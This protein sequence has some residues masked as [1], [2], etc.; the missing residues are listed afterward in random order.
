MQKNYWF[1]LNWLI[2]PWS[3]FSDLSF[4]ISTNDCLN[5]CNGTL[6]NPFQNIIDASTY[7]FNNINSSSELNVSLLFLN[8]TNEIIDQDLI[9]S[10]FSKTNGVLSIFETFS[11]LNISIQPD[12]NL[13]SADLIIKTNSVLFAI[14]K[15]I[16]LK[17][18]NIILDD[19][20]SSLTQHSLFAFLSDNSIIKIENSEISSISSLFLSVIGNSIL[21]SNLIKNG[22]VLIVNS[23]FINISI[24]IINLNS[25]YFSIEFNNNKIFDSKINISFLQNYLIYF[26]GIFNNILIVSLEIHNISKFL[27]MNENNDLHIANMTISTNNDRLLYF[28]KNN[29]VLIDNL[30]ISDSFNDNNSLIFFDD[31]NTALFSNFISKN[32]GQIF[33]LNK[34]NNLIIVYS[35]FFDILGSFLICQFKNYVNLTQNHINN[36]TTNN[37][38][39]IVYI[40]DV[41][42]TLYF[43]ENIFSDIFAN[44][45]GGIISTFFQAEI[46]LTN[47]LFY[48]LTAGI[49]G[50]FIHCVNCQLKIGNSYFN[51]LTAGLGAFLY[52]NNSNISIYNTTIITISSFYRN[53]QSY[54]YSGG[55]IYCYSL[56]A[57]DFS[58]SIIMNSQNALKGG[59][60]HFEKK[61]H[62]Q[63]ESLFIF[64]TS[65][66]IKAACGY[67]YFT[68]TGVINNLTLI[69]SYSPIGLGF[70]FETLNNIIISNSVF[71]NIFYLGNYN[72]EFDLN[73]YYTASP[74]GTLVWLFSNI[75]TVE[76]CTFYDIIGAG[77]S[78]IHLNM[79]NTANIVNITCNNQTNI[80]ND[81]MISLI[82]ENSVNISNS[83]FYNGISYNG[84]AIFSADSSILLIKN[85]VFENLSN[86]NMFSALGGCIYLWQYNNL[87]MTDSSFSNTNG[88]NSGSIYLGNNNNCSIY[89]TVFLNNTAQAEGGTMGGW[90]Q[91]FYYVE[92][93]IF[94]STY[95]YENG[96]VFSIDSNSHAIFI[97]IT[98]I[99]SHAKMQGGCFSI[100]SLINI[101]LINSTFL[102]SS[103]E[104]T[105][106]FAS[107]D[108]NSQ[109]FIQNCLIT[110]SNSIGLGGVFYLSESNKI[111]LQNNVIS[112]SIVQ[113]NGAI[114][115]TK[116]NNIILDTNSYYT[117]FIVVDQTEKTNLGAINADYNNLF[118]WKNISIDTINSMY[119]G[120]FFYC[121]LSNTIR[122]DG[123]FINNVSS[124]LIGGF[125]LF[126]DQNNIEFD[127][128]IANNISTF[129]FGAFIYLF[130]N[131]SF[132]IGNS[133]LS[134]IHSFIHDGGMLYLK[135]S[136]NV[137]LNDLYLNK[138]QCQGSGGFA[139]L[140]TFNY[141]NGNNIN[142]K[143]IF[144]QANGD[145]IYS[146]NNNHVNLFNTTIFNKMIQ[147]KLPSNL[148]YS[149]IMSKI[150]LHGLNS[151]MNCYDDGCILYS[152]RYNIIEINKCYFN[153]TFSAFDYSVLYFYTDN[154]FKMTSSIFSLDESNFKCTFISSYLN[155]TV[156]IL[157]NTFF[158]EYLNWFYQ[159]QISNHL[160]ASNNFIKSTSKIDIV[161]TLYDN[162]TILINR[163]SVSYIITV[164]YIE[165]ISSSII[166]KNFVLKNKYS[167]IVFINIAHTHLKIIRS[168]F[169]NLINQNYA[170]IQAKNCKVILDKV[171][172]FSL[173][174]FM[175]LSVIDVVNVIQ[176]N[177]DFIYN[178]SLKNNIFLKNQGSLGGVL[179]IETYVSKYFKANLQKQNYELIR[180]YFKLNKAIFF[181]GTIFF[182]SN[183]S[184]LQLRIQNNTFHGN[185]AQKGGSLFMKSENPVIISNNKFK[186]SQAKTTKKS[187]SNSPFIGGC[188]FYSFYSLSVNKILILDNNDF[189]ENRA[190]IGGA[191][192]LRNIPIINFTNNSFNKNYINFYGPDFSSVIT[193]L[194]FIEDTYFSDFPIKF[195]ELSNITSG[196][197]YQ[198]CLFQVG[199]FDYFGNLAYNNDEN[200][201]NYISL[202]Q[203]KQLANQIEI[204]YNL[205]NG[206][207]CFNGPFLIKNLSLINQAIDYQIQFK[208]KTLNSLN[209][210]LTFQD[211]HI[212][213]RM[214]EDNE[215]VACEFGTYSLNNNYSQPFLCTP[216]QNNDPFLCEGGDLVRP[217]N[218]FWRID[219]YSDNFLQCL[220]PGLCY[221]LD[222]TYILSKQNTLDDQF[223]TGY[224]II[225]HTG[226]LCG[227]CSD[228]YGKSDQTSCIKCEDNTNWYYFLLIFIKIFLKLLYMFYCVYIGF[229][230]MVSVISN[231]IA[232]EFVCAISLL[233]ILIIHFQILSF[234]P[235]IPLQ[236]SAEFLTALPVL[237]T[238][239]PDMSDAF[240][241][242]CFLKVYNSPIKNVY[243]VLIL[244]P[245]YITVMFLISLS[246][247]FLKK[248]KYERYELDEISSYDLSIFVLFI[249]MILNYIDIGKTNLEMFQ[250]INVASNEASMLRLVNDLNIDCNSMSHRLWMFIICLPVLVISSLIIIFLIFKLFLAYFNKTLNLREVKFSLGYFYIAYKR[251]FFFWDILILIRRLL[252]LF[253]FMFYY[254]NIFFKDLFP[255]ILIYF[256]LIN[257][258]LLQAYFNPFAPEYD[259]LN[260]AELA[261]LFTLSVTYIIII[262]YSTSY[263]KNW[264]FASNY[265][266]LL[267]VGII[268]I[269][270]AF[271]FYWLYFYYSKYLKKK[272]PTF[273]N[274]KGMIKNKTDNTE[275]IATQNSF[276]LF[277]EYLDR[278]KYLTSYSIRN[279][280]DVER[281]LYKDLYEKL[282][283]KFKPYQGTEFNEYLNQKE[284]KIIQNRI[285]SK[286]IIK[287]D[288]KKFQILFGND[289]VKLTEFHDDLQNTIELKYQKNLN[290]CNHSEYFYTDL[291]RIIY[292]KVPNTYN[293]GIYVENTGF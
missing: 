196:S 280:D 114:F 41:G 214:N 64:N 208:N 15:K 229:K 42:N 21:S 107:L 139:Y 225:G 174:G 178:I 148:I 97:N 46:L 271:I 257:S 144:S 117:N 110:N 177:D 126:M 104:Q 213:D 210:R 289:E 203:T 245:I 281:Y 200:L 164:N 38:G 189:S 172:V 36:G 56:N 4:Y 199:G 180:N 275:E 153:Q 254:E 92:N 202:I 28:F 290:Y 22:S 71:R 7:I 19:L 288:K 175:N 51:N 224:C 45:F 47:N 72:Q 261:S 241:F 40:I 176:V 35:S 286:K 50:A 59:I 134:N 98:T 156:Y 183:Q 247:V 113:G 99:N 190:N 32:S 49:W 69:Y 252:I 3:L 39:G 29:T 206:Y 188:I 119:L 124:I 284:K 91:N 151:T 238:L 244:C 73:V 182:I 5:S 60:F 27:Y 10:P 89:N 93:S 26:K 147:K 123:L 20:T 227:V 77:A 215:C 125:A 55:V 268:L 16:Y 260:K 293:Y 37:N 18:L 130:F 228:G 68:N 217:K 258:L 285:I 44:N 95:S 81:A 83:R 133:Y 74:Y 192:Y 220:K 160:N 234:L 239:S 184:N 240:N 266:V 30:S 62:F 150:H 154:Q 242:E 273:I 226:P 283:D 84:P 87:T 79:K 14:T 141:L 76:N 193:K 185:Q 212:G 13:D 194:S 201:K 198:N 80:N 211:C 207:L 276:S 218:D 235:K 232:P 75:L 179:K 121:E 265:F 251:N 94:N 243:L 122:I 120:G 216:C 205:S 181:G 138:V 129:G 11:F 108:E 90:D 221:S 159:S 58:N 88:V 272:L 195:L 236:W 162:S 249:I 223:Y 127:N 109:L 2:F 186:K 78:S 1:F 31:S 169:I 233:K 128:I 145:F 66:Q 24:N 282:N 149:G 158:F 132:I 86:F 101:Y 48:N 12:E 111:T 142:S 8:K 278:N 53:N 270:C 269:N 116:S 146:E 65:S 25:S 274:I 118:I 103:A 131:N 61:N 23:T 85:S 262:F 287:L 54:G 204:N 165:S 102:N 219:K 279:K 82:M 259:V 255:L 34:Q 248:K 6:Q 161:Y 157:G 33:F 63:F 173:A 264:N 171:F 246:L 267:I 143:D 52:A 105:G 250:C 253:T 152:F 67:F 168:S 231:K 237:F 112:Q 230:M 9:N 43:S 57:M 166:M 291:I 96:G 135:D 170:L 209:F 292:K 256:I 191:L 163:E 187:L 140:S 136:N 70:M 222:S 100:G 263:F 137:N 115:F 155:N 167:N 197:Y 277:Q 106:G 17:N